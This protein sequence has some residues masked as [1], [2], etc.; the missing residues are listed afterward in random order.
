[1]TYEQIDLEPADESHR[2]PGQSGRKVWKRRP[3]NGPAKV[4]FD[5]ITAGHFCKEVLAGHASLQL[6]VRR[7]RGR[8]I[9]TLSLVNNR[10]TGAEEGTSVPDILFQVGMTCTPSLGIPGYPD[11]EVI[12][13]DR[14]AEELA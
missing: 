2:A 10:G 12:S 3:C 13:P 8:M 11:P 7:S 5:T 14:E 4:T 1:A 9:A 6:F